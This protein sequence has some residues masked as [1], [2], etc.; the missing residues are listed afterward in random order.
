MTNLVYFMTKFIIGLRLECHR[1]NK[2]ET[3]V[4]DIEQNIKL[5]LKIQAGIQSYRFV[6]AFITFL[7]L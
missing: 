3:Y 2:V 4:Y 1:F 7:P 5:N 6:N